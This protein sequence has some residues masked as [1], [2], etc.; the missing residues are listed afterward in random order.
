MSKT[1]NTAN[2]TDYLGGIEYDANALK[3]ISFSVGYAELLPNATYEYKY[4]ITDH[5]GNTRALF[6]QDATTLQRNHYYAFGLSITS[7]D[8]SGPG[9][10]WKYQYNGKEKQTD[11]GFGWYDYGFRFYDPV[12]ARFPQLD[13]LANDFVYLTPYQYAGNGPISN[14]DL[15]GLE[16]WQS[17]IPA[18]TAWYV[19]SP[20]AQAFFKGVGNYA[21]GESMQLSNP[22]EA[23]L[24]TLRALDNG[25]LFNST[26]EEKSE[27]QGSFFAAVLI[28]VGLTIATMGESTAASVADDLA[29]GGTGVANGLDD[30]GRAAKSGSTPSLL[31]DGAGMAPAAV[32]TAETQGATRGLAA[33]K[34]GQQGGPGAGKRFS[35]KVKLQAKAEA[36]GRCVFCGNA[37]TNTPG[38]LKGNTDHAV[39]KSQGGN[40][41]LDNAQHT[42]QTCNFGKGAQTTEQFLNRRNQ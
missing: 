33:P 8:F 12:V 19:S 32:R 30:L 28:E 16:P 38:P 34:A 3:R 40:N 22:K 10:A 17:I 21:R 15:D 11:F 23:I 35:E 29:R 14:V 18:I 7:L 2:K 37:T 36:E 25:S 27:A 41:T 42:C 39:P 9:A 31:S 1:T 13:P 24:T 4:A 26:P 5:L 20:N 6:S